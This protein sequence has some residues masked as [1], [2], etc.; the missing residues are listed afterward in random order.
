VNGEFPT[1]QSPCKT[2]E[3]RN[4]EVFRENLFLKAFLVSDDEATPV[5]EP[6]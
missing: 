1:I 4:L 6:T 5:R 2:S 3:L